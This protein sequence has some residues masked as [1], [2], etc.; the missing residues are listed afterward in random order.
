MDKN[1]FEGRVI[2]IDDISKLGIPDI[3]NYVLLAKRRIVPLLQGLIVSSYS[4]DNVYL[5]TFGYRS[6]HF[7]I[8]SPGGEIFINRNGLEAEKRNVIKKMDEDPNYLIDMA[9]RCEK[10]GNLFIDEVRNLQNMDISFKSDNYLSKITYNM[11]SHIIN[12][13]AYIVFPLSIEHLLESNVKTYI[14]SKISNPELRDKYF[15]TLTTP[16]KQDAIFNERVEILKLAIEYKKH[17]DIN[18]IKDKIE[19]YLST[20]NVIGTRYGVGKLWSYS[21]IVRRIKELA[22]GSPEKDLYYLLDVPKKDDAN[23]EHVLKILDANDEFKHVVKIARLYVYLRT[24]RTDVLSMGFGYMFPLF[25]EI[26]KRN[27]L[28]L[29]HV[30]ASLPNEV[31]E[32]NF[33]EPKFIEKRHKTIMIGGR[34]GVVYYLYGPEGTKLYNSLL[35]V[36]NSPQTNSTAI[37]GTVA[38]IGVVR[39]YVKVVKDWKEINRVKQG[40]ILVCTMT[41]PNFIPAMEK[42]AA[43]V[44]DEGGIL[45]HAAIVSREMDKPCIVGTGNATKV[46]HDGDYV[47]VDA[48]KGVVRILGR[49]G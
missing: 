9:K 17:K 48:D 10:K 43:F 18:R 12:I 45:C 46:L 22:N 8:Y 49:Q 30:L 29:Q 40:D 42:A 2:R 47:E 36:I 23:A 16:L 4:D 5:E 37:K 6:P 15:H 41:T 1:R 27:N 24:Y 25:E 34:K 31:L 19:E 28:T 3:N 33:P 26:A 13:C 39:G 38:N 7:P 11:F 44:T 14:H 20:Y 21:D 35:N 32:F